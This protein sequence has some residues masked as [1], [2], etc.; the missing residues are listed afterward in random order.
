MIRVTAKTEEAGR[1]MEL[2]RRG[3]TP[4][5]IDPVVERV[6]LETLASIIDA[7]PKRWFGQVR[8]G[9]HIVRPAP[10][11]R[12]IRNENQIMWFLEHGTAQGGAGY[13]TP[14]RTKVL[15]VPLTRAAA[16]GWRPGLVF[17]QDYILAKRV[18]GIKPRH[19]AATETK[20]AEQRLLAAMHAHIHRLIHG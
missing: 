1:K 13:I 11:A 9:W 10:G 6:A 19:I 8:R 14:K 5:R 15:Y 17:G 16:S 18:R 12:L 7:T 2:V 3:L 20:K 4:E